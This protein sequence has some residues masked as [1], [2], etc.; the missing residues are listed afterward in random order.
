MIHDL[1]MKYYLML[2]ISDLVLIF[3][4]V[5]MDVCRL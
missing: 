2:V 1:A 4:Y 3:K 5:F